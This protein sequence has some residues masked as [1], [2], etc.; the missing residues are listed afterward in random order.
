MQN[1]PIQKL[2]ENSL[3]SS[4]YPDR[5][6]D[7]DRLERSISLFGVLEA[8]IVSESPNSP[9]HFDIISGNRRKK[10]AKAVG[11]SMVPCVVI[12]PIPIDEPLIRAHQEHRKKR[13]SEQLKEVVLLYDRYSEVLKQGVRVTNNPEVTTARAVRQDLENQSGGKHTVSR[14]RQYHELA[15]TFSKE[16]PQV[17]QECLV[18][19]DKS[20]SLM[21]AIKSL[22]R[23]IN[24][25][26]N[27]ERVVGLEVVDLE[28]IKVYLKDSSNPAELEPNTVQLVITSPPYFGIRD[29]DLGDNE[30]GHEG[31]MKEFVD[32][33][34]EHLDRYKPL[35]KEDG[36]MWVNIGDYIRDYTYQLSPEYLVYGMI[37]KGWLIQDKLIWLKKNPAFNNAERSVVAHEYIYV[38]KKNPFAKYSMSWV[39][40]YPELIGVMSYGTIKGRV[41]LRSVLDFRDGVLETATANN[42]SVAKACKEQGITFTH[43]AT[44]PL[45]VPLAAILTSTDVGDLVVDPFNGSGTSGRAAQILRRK[46]VGYELNPQYL[47]QTEMRLLMPMSADIELEA[48]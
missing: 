33:L 7:M 20:K 35:L 34:I 44:F 42:S 15:K 39:K 46:Y 36:T 23:T 3:T 21:G 4:L 19:L 48:A 8:L 6:E 24:E 10:A 1:I 38:F 26:A 14:L 37:Q 30:L 22:D 43:N 11:L 29:Y 41:K 16:D 47:K 5:S 12:D 9:G 40:M 27:L 17:Y 25:A 32:R 13:R 28:D 31:T 18:K 45:A 2:I